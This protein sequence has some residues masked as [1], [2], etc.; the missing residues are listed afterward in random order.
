MNNNWPR[1]PSEHVD[2]LL[3]ELD[4]NARIGLAPEM[5]TGIASM[6]VVNSAIRRLQDDGAQEPENFDDNFEAILILAKCMERIR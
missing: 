2:R 6:A 5:D 4:W 1:C 3:R